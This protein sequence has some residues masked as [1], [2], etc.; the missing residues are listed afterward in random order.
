MSEPLA[1]VIAVALE[2]ARIIDEARIRQLIRE[3]LANVQASPLESGWL[4][5]PQAAKARGV[6]LKR[7]RVLMDA[8]RVTVRSKNPASAHPKFEI[9]LSSL[10]AALAPAPEPARP[11]DAASWAAQRAARKAAP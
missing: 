7:I 4:S 11:V 9:S 5:P 2:Q 10:D 1:R 6:S 3:E 8:G